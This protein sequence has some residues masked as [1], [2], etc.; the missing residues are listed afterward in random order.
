M[1]ISGVNGGSNFPQDP[2]RQDIGLAEV[3]LTE[4]QEELQMLQKSVNFLH[5]LGNE[6]GLQK[7]VQSEIQKS[8]TEIKKSVEDLRNLMDSHKA[9]FSKSQQSELDQIICFTN[10]LNPSDSQSFSNDM[11]CCQSSL[12]NLLE[13]LG[14]KR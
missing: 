5:Q 3:K 2:S 10:K 11:A 8:M 1:Q 4:L 6:P 9:S 12:N 13:D 7:V 14:G